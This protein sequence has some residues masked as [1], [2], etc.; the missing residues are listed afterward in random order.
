[1]AKY[2]SIV[3]VLEERIEHGDYLIN[4][5]PS[6]RKL[7][8][9]TGVSHMTARKVTQVLLEKGLLQRMENGRLAASSSRQESAAQIAFVSPA[10]PSLLNYKWMG[11]VISACAD[12]DIQIRPFEYKHFNDV[13]LPQILESVDGVFFVS[14]AEALPPE[15]ISMFQEAD[16][17]VVS[18][19]N[20]M[21]MHGIP[22]VLCHLPSSIDQLLA[23]LKGLGHQHV[24]AFNAQPEDSTI[25]DRLMRLRQAGHE[26][27][28]T[29]EVQSWPVESFGNSLPQAKKALRQILDEGPLQATAIVAVTESASIGVIRVLY[30]RGI[31]VPE[32]ISVCCVA[33]E[34]QCE[35]YIP[36][37]TTFQ[38]TDIK[39]L[40]SQ[41]LK[42]MIT[43]SWQ[44]DLLLTP[45]TVSLFQ[46]E[47]TSKAKA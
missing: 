40:V 9:E 15:L 30:E 7:A 13:V 4:D 43:R 25:M 42:D 36:A 2:H 6:E 41:A 23:H 29:V 27:G 47:S 24:M 31:R 12:R 21:S 16:A 37:I 19:D 22:S 1:M 14:K 5:F 17:F 34:G 10:Y 28:L 18:L 8:A 11:N 20:D 35:S 39:S 3:Q 46:G 33:N 26:L 44:G 45:A 38:E 32:D